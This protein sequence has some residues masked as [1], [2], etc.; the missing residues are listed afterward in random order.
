M[1]WAW[2]NRPV[3]GLPGCIEHLSLPDVAAASVAQLAERNPPFRTRTAKKCPSIPC[4]GWRPTICPQRHLHVHYLLPR[5]G[6]ALP[7]Y[8]FQTVVFDEI[9]ELRHRGTENT[10][11]RPAGKRRHLLMAFL[12]HRYTT[13]GNMEHRQHFRLSVSGRLKSFSRSGAMGMATPLSSSPIC[14]ANTYV[15]RACCATPSGRCCP[16]A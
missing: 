14:W 13:S 8:A 15:A 11:L 7:N 5:A 4:R 9:Q 3:P 16:A 12:A 1:R 10:P 2:E 6:K